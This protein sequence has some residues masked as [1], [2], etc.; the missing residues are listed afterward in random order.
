MAIRP[1]W[2]GVRITVMLL[3]LLVMWF[4]MN[5]KLVKWKDSTLCQVMIAETIS[6]AHNRSSVDG[7][8]FVDGRR[9]SAKVAV[10]QKD[11]YLSSPSESIKDSF[12][13]HKSP[14][15]SVLRDIQMVLIGDSVM[16]YQYLSLAFR[17]K[18]GFWFDETMWYYN[19]VNERS[20]D[21]PYHNHTWGEFLFHTHQ[22]LQPHEV[23]CDCHRK[24]VA[25]M[26]Q[27]V[28]NRYYHDPVRN[29]SLEFFLAYGHTS[30]LSGRLL[31]HQ[32]WNQTNEWQ[33]LAFSKFQGRV[34]KHHDWSDAIRHHVQL[35]NPQPRHIVMN[36][37]L[38]SHKFGWE[39]TTPAARCQLM[40][41]IC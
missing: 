40:Q 38:W 36:A 15:S 4:L 32:V 26:L 22:I 17:L 8:F 11:E 41:R 1:N 6:V 25:A 12:L 13:Q 34:W 30:P 23:T 14:S 19:L 24:P 2:N 31:P 28:E 5:H 33:K 20:F 35:L 29:N 16:R 7:D 27:V 10:S 39:Q 9:F 3:S 37:G 18:Y 21:D